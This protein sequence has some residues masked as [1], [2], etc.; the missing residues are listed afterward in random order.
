MSPD[1]AACTRPSS[2]GQLGV[3]GQNHTVSPGPWALTPSHSSL[4]PPPAQAGLS[5]PGKGWAFPLWAQHSVP[6]TPNPSTCSHCPPGAAGN[7]WPLP[8]RGLPTTHPPTHYM[9]RGFFPRRRVKLGAASGQPH[10][11]TRPTL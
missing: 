6:R 9:G 5:I 3:P 11:L 10:T 2:L 1:P 4:L 7:I 8:H